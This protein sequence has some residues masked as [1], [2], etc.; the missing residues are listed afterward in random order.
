MVVDTES[1]RP[2]RS[3]QQFEN[4]DWQR[5]KHKVSD[6]ENIL[7]VS[8]TINVKIYVQLDDFYFR[9]IQSINQ[10][11]AQCTRIVH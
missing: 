10:T 5:R 3:K 8:E 7:A 9:L 6:G 2:D 1:P 11:I 4:S